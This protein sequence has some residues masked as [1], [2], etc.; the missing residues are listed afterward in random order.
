[1]LEPLLRGACEG[2]SAAS[3]RGQGEGIRRAQRPPSRAVLWASRQE[4]CPTLLAQA[5]ACTPDT[6]DS[7]STGLRRPV[8]GAPCELRLKPWEDMAGRGP[9]CGRGPG[10]PLHLGPFLMGPSCWQAAGDAGWVRAPSCSAQPVPGLPCSRLP[11]GNPVTPGL[12]E[13]VSPNAGLGCHLGMAGRS[14]LQ[15]TGESCVWELT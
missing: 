4:I 9:A 5:A 2:L 7:S 8:P 12:P 6:T 13:P 11:A 1:M 14:H 10:R 15:L 3:Q